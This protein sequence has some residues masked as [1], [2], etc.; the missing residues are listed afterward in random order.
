MTSHI[1]L[2][3]EDL[4]DVFFR[5]DKDLIRRKIWAR[6]PQASKGIYP[7]IGV[8]C[9]AQG[10]AKPSE[11]TI[12]ILA[13]VTEKTVRTGINGLLGL[14]G[15]RRDRYVTVRGHRA[16]SYSIRPPPREKG[17][18]FFF[19]KRIIAGGIWLHL[20]PTAQALYP[21]LRHFAYSDWFDYEDGESSQ[22]YIEQL[23]EYGERPYDLAD[24]E[25]DVLAEYSG[26]SVTSVHVALESLE[27]HF[28]VKRDL[29]DDGLRRWQ[30]FFKP[31][32]FYRR[33]Y[34][35]EKIAKRYGND[36]G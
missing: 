36:S 1:Y 21:V 26:I 27:K 17:R 4:N 31:V 7:V 10:I 2:F 3:K 25:M 33:E 23:S 14:P 15:F 34:L 28:L 16:Y 22:E 8:H 20:K 5:F 12:A 30:I 35:N 13:G 9:N 19:H 24:A 32:E 18:V 29:D 6:L 11:L